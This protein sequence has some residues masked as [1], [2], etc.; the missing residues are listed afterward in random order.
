[1]RDSLVLVRHLDWGVGIANRA[2]YGPAR[3]FQGV[4]DAGGHIDKG[5]EV[6]GNGHYK[7]VG[8]VY[9]SALVGCRSAVSE[10]SVSVVKRS[11]EAGKARYAVPRYASLR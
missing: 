10:G 6:D 2:I 9:K 8:A 3:K 7:R 11:V 5:L 1:M 4:H